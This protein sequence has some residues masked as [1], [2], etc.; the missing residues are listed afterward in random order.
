[1]RSRIIEAER[2]VLGVFVENFNGAIIQRMF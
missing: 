2:F 1:M